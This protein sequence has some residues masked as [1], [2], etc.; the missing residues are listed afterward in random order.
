MPRRYRLAVAG[1]PWHIILRGNTRMRLEE[2]PEIKEA[3]RSSIPHV[4]D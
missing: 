1:I 4:H 3:V 2:P